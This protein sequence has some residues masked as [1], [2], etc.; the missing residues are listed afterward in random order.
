MRL[1]LQLRH[2]VTAD[3]RDWDE[4]LPLVEFALNSCYHQAIRS[5]P[6][7]MNRITLPANPL[8][9]LLDNKRRLPSLLA[10]WARHLCHAKR[11]APMHRLTKS[12]SERAGV[13]KLLS[14]N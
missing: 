3:M 6:F 7:R 2:Y 1:S 4:M 10:G 13:C 11:C 8:D 5:S 12:I 14:A 9:V